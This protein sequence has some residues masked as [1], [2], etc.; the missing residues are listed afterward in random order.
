MR[1]DWIKK[2]EAAD[3]DLKLF[4]L[5]LCRATPTGLLLKF[6]LSKAPTVKQSGTQPHNQLL[7]GEGL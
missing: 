5:R 7:L 1:I 6:S 3:V 2:V 4:T